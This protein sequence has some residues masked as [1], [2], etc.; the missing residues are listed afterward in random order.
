MIY[1]ICTMHISNH[2]ILRQWISRP[3]TSESLVSTS[4]EEGTAR[5]RVPLSQSLRSGRQA[6]MRR[7]DCRMTQGKDCC[8]FTVLLCTGRKNST[9]WNYGKE[10]CQCIPKIVIFKYEI[11]MKH[12][13]N[14][15]EICMKY[16]WHMCS[17]PPS[18]SMNALWLCD[19][20]KET[21]H[22]FPLRPAMV[23][24]KALLRP[25]VKNQRAIWQNAQCAHPDYPLVN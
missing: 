20:L 23:L 18:T 6:T 5:W 19:G 21:T 14:M 25:W 3:S 22:S 2:L 9:V 13:W 16:V 11:C 10:V 12:V 15:Y 7:P 8:D 17:S 24:Q 4:S 1:I